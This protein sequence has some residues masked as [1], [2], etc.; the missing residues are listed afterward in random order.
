VKF[1]ITGFDWDDGNRQ[2]CQKHGLSLPEIEE[3]LRR[4]DL[5]VN[6]T[7]THGA[8]EKRF[9]AAGRGQEGRPTLVIFTVRQQEQQTLLRPISARYMHEKEVKIYDSKEKISVPFLF[10]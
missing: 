8:A 1:N 7:T 5:F 6:T 9:I 4:D 3:F 10:R 2:K